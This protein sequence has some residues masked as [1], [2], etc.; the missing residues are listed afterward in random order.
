MAIQD[1]VGCVDTLCLPLIVVP[2][3][4]K[5]PNIIT[6]N[7]DGKNDALAFQYLEFYPQ[8]ELKVLNRW[9][10]VVFEQASYA[11]TWEGGDLTEGVYFYTLIIKEKNQTYTGFFHLVR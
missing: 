8:N 2:A 6:P 11:N 7:G 1:A 5:T 9:G 3:E 10:S 4:V